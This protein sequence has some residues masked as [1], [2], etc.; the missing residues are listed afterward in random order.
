[1]RAVN[2]GGYCTGAAA[3]ID[4]VNSDISD[5]GVALGSAVERVVAGSAVDAVG[6]APAIDRVVVGSAGDGIE[7]AIAEEAVVVVS[8]VDAVVVVSTVDRVVAAVAGH[9]V[10]ADVWLAVDGVE[11]DRNRRGAAVDDDIEQRGITA[12]FLE[13]DHVIAGRSGNQLRRQQSA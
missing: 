10:V 11:R 2:G 12:V 7:P 6:T 8:A 5:E 13:D 1:G 9:A 3:V 4:E